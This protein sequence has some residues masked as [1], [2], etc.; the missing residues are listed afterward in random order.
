M[1][2]QDQTEGKQGQQGQQGEKKKDRNIGG[3]IDDAK[4]RIKEAAGALADDDDLRREGSLDRAAGAA[5][6]RLSDAIDQVR[7]G[8]GS[9]L[10]DDE[11]DDDAKKRQK[12]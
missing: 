1:A 8:V 7:E 9:L 11:Q 6:E 3:A 12:S 2:K 4:G 5:K 10:G